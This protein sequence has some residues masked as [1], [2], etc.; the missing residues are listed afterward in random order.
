VLDILRNACNPADVADVR[1]YLTRR[2]LWPLPSG[3]TLNAHAS[4]EFW[5]ERQRVGRFAALLAEVRDVA[6][7]LV[8]V[9]ITYLAAG[10]KL[11]QHQ[12]RKILSPLTGRAGCAVR[13][14]PLQGDVL[15]V[16]EGLETC[17]AAARLHSMVVWAALN[18]VLLGKFEPPA[19]VRRLVVFADRDTPGLE[20]AV[21]L[22]EHLRGRL[23]I[24]VRVP[25][26][27]AK[28]W[29]DVIIERGR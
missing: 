26:A 4:A 7:E 21:R 12:P 3:C 27:P 1:E 11:A 2:E 6:G 8:T 25:P 10:Q 5:H 15:G 14:L 29:A 19:H 18:I 9:H 16:G 23:C 17:L 20:A 24:E 28:D 13:L 22:L